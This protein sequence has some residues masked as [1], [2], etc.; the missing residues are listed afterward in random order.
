MVDSLIVN[1][2][3]LEAFRPVI[4]CDKS[5]V[6]CSIDPFCSSDPAGWPLFSGAQQTRIS[7]PEKNSIPGVKNFCSSFGNW[8]ER[9]LNTSKE[10]PKPLSRFY[11]SHS[12][13]MVRLE[14][15]PAT[16]KGAVGRSTPNQRFLEDT[17]K[18]NTFCRDAESA[19]KKSGEP[20][21]KS[22]DI[23]FR[24]EKEI[25]DY[26]KDIGDFFKDEAGP[27]LYDKRRY[28]IGFLLGFGVVVI[29]GTF[30]KLLMRGGKKEQEKKIEETQGQA[31]VDPVAEYN[32]GLE[33]VRNELKDI[34]TVEFDV[35]SLFIGK[36]S[37]TLRQLAEALP[38]IREQRTS[39]QLFIETRLIDRWHKAHPKKG[40]TPDPAF[41][42]DFA[43]NYK[44]RDLEF[45][46][47]AAPAWMERQLREA[48]S[49]VPDEIRAELGYKGYVDPPSVLFEFFDRI[50]FAVISFKPLLQADKPHD[51]HIGRE[52][53][54]EGVPI[55]PITYMLAELQPL[56][57][58]YPDLLDLQARTL[59]EIWN[60]FVA[61][62]KQGK[63]GL[64]EDRYVNEPVKRGD[65]TS[66]YVHA[67]HEKLVTGAAPAVVSRPHVDLDVER[68]ISAQLDTGP[69]PR[70]LLFAAQTLQYINWQH[71]TQVFEALQKVVPDFKKQP[72]FIQLYLEDVLAEPV[73]QLKNPGRNIEKFIAEHL[74]SLVQKKTGTQIIR[75]GAMKQQ[76]SVAVE[77]LKQE[78]GNWLDEQSRRVWKKHSDQISPKQNGVIQ[79]ALGFQNVEEF[80]RALR[81]VFSRE[82]GYIVFDPLELFNTDN[83][84]K[85]RYE[86]ARQKS[87]G[88]INLGDVM[89]SLAKESPALARYPR[90]IELKAYLLIDSWMNADAFT[91]DVIK[92]FASKQN[93]PFLAKG[94]PIPRLYVHKWFVH[95]LEEIG[96]EG[97][98]GP[99]E[100]GVVTG[101]ED[102]G[103]VKGP[104][105]KV[106][107]RTTLSVKANQLVTGA[108]V[109]LGLSPAA[110]AGA[111]SPVP[112]KPAFVR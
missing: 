62:E 89:D 16:A 7:S 39:V 40:A 45:D 42:V 72:L 10:V 47:V 69:K 92:E 97:P 105:S 51:L 15:E 44:S 29:I 57:K 101:F 93:D 103:D 68:L 55:G 35:P 82:P 58:F 96:N 12:G 19:T 32:K 46:Q 31:G 27:Y 100:G 98:K 66:L 109:Y 94:W 59:G 9:F 56:L 53:L 8:Q 11:S 20:P 108:K 81:E 67:L 63:I 111:R 1:K 6:N 36:Q 21:S 38:G 75:K 54:V 79:T 34:T 22:T 87:Y 102:G 91:Q 24:R 78:A 37:D 3:F 65:I 30:I 5:V 74:S 26:L 77:Q 104:G 28:G 60:R 18:I 13:T 33:I 76:I 23:N 71:R 14:N 64:Q 110:G 17:Q 107:A 86:A 25:G 43:K 99:A 85:A 88:G 61:E 70:S 73:T 48:W 4:C 90:F 84:A 106:V 41:I 80:S 2:R 50:P 112:L 83:D 49:Q 95:S 52:E